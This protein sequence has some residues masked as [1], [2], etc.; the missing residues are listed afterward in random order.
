MDLMT[1]LVYAAIAAV[2][3]GMGLLVYLVFSLIPAKADVVAAVAPPNEAE[4][5]RVE[6][7]TFS[8]TLAA[9]MPTG[10]AGWVQKKII[11][12]GKA[13]IWTVG[14]FLIVRLV[15]LVVAVLIA[16]GALLLTQ[17][18]F[19]RI[20][21]V[22]FAVLIFIVPEVILSSRADDRQKEILLALPDT[23]D[24][25][26]IAVEAGLGFEAAMARAAQGTRGAL[27]E[28][29]IR[30]LQDM[31]IGRSR[32]DAYSAL[33]ARTDCDD[34]KRFIRAVQ[35]ADRYG[36]A[37]ADVLRVQASEM[38]IRRRQRAEEQ[39]MKVPIKVVFPLVFAILPVLFIVLLYPAVIG[40][41]NQFG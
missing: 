4:R 38:R 14:G 31:S 27:S 16:G 3:I 41:M 37:V 15:L 21:G 10:Y 8:Q 19:Q 13:G 36:I 7:A 2:G 12:A 1:V 28:E 11:Y 30:T 33:L 5:E 18:T 6:R 40:I 17:D 20:I 23:L 25:M 9:V 26:T 29:L 22:V 24:Q 32:S 35:Q 39:A 34:L